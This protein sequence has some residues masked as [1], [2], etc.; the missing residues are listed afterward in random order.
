MVASGTLD[1]LYLEAALPVRLRLVVAN[2]TA[3]SVAERLGSGIDVSSVSESS[4]SLSCFN[5][6][7]MAVIRRIGDLGDMV[8]D[9]QI[10]PP[11][12][13]EVYSHFMERRAS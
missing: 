7:K 3:S 10:K 8:E 11:K 6:D 9:L 12:L 1:E 2:G 13:D 5:G 4:L